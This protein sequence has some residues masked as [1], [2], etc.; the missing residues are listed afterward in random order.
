MPDE[1]KRVFS[2]ALQLYERY[3][4]IRMTEN[5]W[6]KLTDDLAAFETKWNFKENPLAYHI[7][8][9]IIETLGD[10]YK[11]GKTPAIA[12]YFGRDDL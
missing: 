7:G 9:A 12:D 6:V 10:M 5:D 3:R 2:E 4:S 8:C 1:E 11:D